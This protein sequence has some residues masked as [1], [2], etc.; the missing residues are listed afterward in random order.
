[1]GEPQTDARAS[2]RR[3]PR[4]GPRPLAL[5]LGTAALT[6]LSSESVL[7]H[8]MS[9]SLPWKPALLDA[10]AEL[11]AS[12]DGVA[13]EALAAALD[14]EV[15]RRLHLFL[16]GL[17]R[18]RHHPYRRA[19][20][21]PPVLWQQGT[22]RLLDYGADREGRGDGGVRRRAGRG[23]NVALF[24]PSLV[25]RGYI[26]DLAEGNSLLRWIAGH[27][28]RPLLVDWGRPGPVERGFDLTDYVAGRLE[29][30]L[31][32]AVA[33]AGGPIAVVGYCMGGNL[34]L[35]LAQRRPDT[36]R[37]LALLAT[38]WD[39]HADRPELSRAVAAAAEPLLH[40]ADRLGE[41][42][43]DVLQ[44]L[45]FLL[46]PYLA[47][48]KFLR[49]ANFEP[50]SPRELAFVALEDW[51][52]DGVPLAAAVARECLSGWYGENTAGRG[53]W[54]I[55]GQAVEPRAIG[56]PSLVV[57]P[58]Q[59]RIVP[60]ASAEPLARLIPGAERLQPSLGHIG[61]V[62][63]GRAPR[64]LWQPLAAWLVRTSAPRPK[65]SRRRRALPSQLRET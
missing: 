9:G 13:A 60:P 44:A 11:R 17:E 16:L 46:D 40:A 4:L 28:V 31:D 29:A 6:W 2:P 43:T 36:V 24:V 25:N 48:R 27:G 20:A 19:L 7:P 50:G 21:E 53:A 39:F 58:A 10:A 55:A 26:L 38:P 64:A 54:R 14:R 18:Y 62:V 49:F 63:G 45:F 15:R 65:G 51:L 1:M 61:M 30:A 23:G 34:A 41:L 59:D 56:V 3:P 42:S 8:L 33:A 52:N 57:V 47:P 37:A 12:L 22:T 5:H 32:A 35:A